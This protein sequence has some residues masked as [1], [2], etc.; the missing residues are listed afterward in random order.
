MTNIRILLNLH[1]LLV[2]TGCDN[3][4]FEKIKH[5][6]SKEDLEYFTE[7]AF[8]SEFRNNKTKYEPSLRYWKSDINV[9][10]NGHYTVDDSIEVLRVIAELNELINTI[11]ISLV[12]NFGNVNIYFD[13]PSTFY[14]FPGFVPGNAGFFCVKRFRIFPNG[15]IL[16]DKWKSFNWRKHLI[17]E[18]LTQILGLMSD[19]YSYPESI[20][21][22]GW[23]DINEYSEIDRQLIRL[24]YNYN[25]PFGMKK[26]D[27]IQLINNI[28]SE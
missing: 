19:S 25:L 2:L 1:L 13:C 16:I 5:D 6:F 8:G 18:E 26:S 28:K 27:F 3:I 15:Y 4:N 9:H 22:Q 7:I 23:T 14:N 21:F 11:D 10:L 17:R 20:F 12:G 24:L